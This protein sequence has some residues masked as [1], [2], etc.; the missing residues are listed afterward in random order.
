M[1]K[2]NEGLNNKITPEENVVDTTT[3]MEDT[4]PQVQQP[5]QEQVTEEVTEEV[6]ISPEEWQIQPQVQQPQ[7]VAPTPVVEQP[8]PVTRGEAVVAETTDQITKAE[9]ALEGAWAVLS[10][11]SDPRKAQEDAVKWEEEGL[12]K[13][14]SDVTWPDGKDFN[15]KR[16][17]W[18]WFSP[19]LWEELV[20][21]TKAELVDYINVTNRVGDAGMVGWV[22]KPQQPLDRF[23]EIVDEDVRK[24][25][26]AEA[27]P[28]LEPVIWEKAQP[29]RAK[30]Y[31]VSTV[32]ETE[33]AEESLTQITNQDREIEKNVLTLWKDTP[34]RVEAIETSRSKLIKDLTVLQNQR[35][36]TINSLVGKYWQLLNTPDFEEQDI[37]SDIKGEIN[38]AYKDIQSIQ[39][40]LN[41]MDEADRSLYSD[42]LAEVA[43]EAPQSYINALV[44]KRRKETL[45][46]KQAKLT[47]LKIAE[48]RYGF[49]SEQ[50]TNTKEEREI[51]RQQKFDTIQKEIDRIN[52]EYD[53]RIELTT[54]IWELRVA[55]DQ[56]ML[57]RQ[58]WLTSTAISVANLPK[59]FSMQVGDNVFNGLEENDSYSIQSYT[60]A[61]NN[62]FLMAVNKSDPTDNMRI[63]MGRGE[64]DVAKALNEYQG[65]KLIDQVFS[66]EQVDFESLNFKRNINKDFQKETFVDWFKSLDSNFK[67]MN[68]VLDESLKI[69]IEWKTNEEIERSRASADEALI[70]LFNKMLDYNSVVREWEFARSIQQQWFVDQMKWFIERATTGS[71]WISDDTR[72]NMVQIARILRD[73]AEQDYL[74]VQRKYQELWKE[75]GIEPS[76]FTVWSDQMLE[77]ELQKGRYTDTEKIKIREDLPWFTKWENTRLNNPIWI[78]VTPF[79]QDLF[80]NAWISFTTGWKVWDTT[81]GSYFIFETVDEAL[82]AQSVTWYSNLWDMPL[83]N[84]LV[85]WKWVST[86]NKELSQQAADV[87]AKDILTNAFGESYEEYSKKSYNDLNDTE[88]QAFI[89]SQFKRENVMAYNSYISNFQ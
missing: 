47:E 18:G 85:N 25:A 26:Q 42:V 27:L 14:V 40:E 54:Q 56:A 44:A 6:T 34:N 57:D 48:D 3:Q 78:K 4:T 68:S 24:A 2:K 16:T 71:A 75:A 83:Y 8:S 5:T 62:S 13:V 73:A 67:K 81:G 23:W 88:K 33:F 64:D 63:F 37:L 19:E 77:K 84:W 1:A 45:P 46:D 58:K 7:Q 12:Y 32:K 79:K 82:E 50:L 17:I 66:G 51:Q 15:L 59:G 87:Y 31:D 72:K 52:E 43:G 28:W 21:K 38:D 69:G 9:E 39:L 35:N 60:D 89:L 53:K 76:F 86:T 20:F 74:P 11:P 70:F 29:I 61:D 30:W 49:Y 22:Y 55:E 36:T 10:T 80:N 65:K 41:E